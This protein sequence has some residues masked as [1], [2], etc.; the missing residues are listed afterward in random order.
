MVNRKGKKGLIITIII[1]VI[2]LIAVGGFALWQQTHKKVADTSTPVVQTPVKV[3]ETD[4]DNPAATPEADTPPASQ[5]DPA[6]LSTIDIEPM[7][8][9]V[10]YTKGIPGFEFSVLRTAD[11]TQYVEF[12]SPD[13][14]GTKC[15]NDVGVFVSII[16]NPTSS[17]DGVTISQKKTV[18]NDT[19][20]LSLATDTCTSDAEL[21]K[22]YQTAFINGFDQLKEIE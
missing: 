13:L 11:R 8:L 1:L 22:E 9:K 21:L 5:V 17:A 4:T 20:G 19:Y 12:S 14:V 3:E 7:N 10:S 16:K 18:G 6:S 2:V 15:T